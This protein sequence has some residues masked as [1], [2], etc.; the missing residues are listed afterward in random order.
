MA[1]ALSHA[2][3]RAVA[4]L[5]GLLSALFA[6]ASIP[7]LFAWALDNSRPVSLTPLVLGAGLL[8]IAGILLVVRRLLHLQG[9]SRGHSH[10]TVQN[11]SSR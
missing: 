7:I 1:A 6:A 10:G 11:A 8:G 5:C 3:T 2:L 9:A 4:S